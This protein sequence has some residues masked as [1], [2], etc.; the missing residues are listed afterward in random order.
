MVTGIT[1]VWTAM[2]NTHVVPA[3]SYIQKLFDIMDFDRDGAV[4]FD[5]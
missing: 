1:Q 3:K 4:S 2:T 5:E